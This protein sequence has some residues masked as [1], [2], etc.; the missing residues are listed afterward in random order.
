MTPASTKEEKAKANSIGD[1]AASTDD[2]NNTHTT[3]HHHTSTKHHRAAFNHSTT[4][5]GNNRHSGTPHH[6]Q[7]SGTHLPNQPT[8]NGP[9]PPDHKAIKVL[10]DSRKAKGGRRGNNNSNGNRDS[11]PRPQT[12]SCS[13]HRLNRDLSSISASSMASGCFVSV[14]VPM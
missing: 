3:T 4:N 7:S 10:K 13:E 12:T 9:H 8:S 5:N 6:H 2:T 11:T 1:L 14:K